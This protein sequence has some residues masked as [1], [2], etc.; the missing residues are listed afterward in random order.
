MNAELETL[1]TNLAMALNDLDLDELP[2]LGVYRHNVSLNIA[3]VDQ[4]HQLFNLVDVEDLYVKDLLQCCCIEVVK[5][6]DSLIGLKLRSH[7]S[8]LDPIYWLRADD[9]LSGE[10]MSRVYDSLVEFIDSIPDER[11]EAQ[12]INLVKC[13][14]LIPWRSVLNHIVNRPGDVLLG[15]LNHPQ[16]FFTPSVG[17]YVKI[18][19]NHAQLDIEP[20]EGILTKEDYGDDSVWFTISEA[21]APNTTNVLTCKS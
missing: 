6:H 9:K 18:K 17:L 3:S 8:N 2:W 7:R 16:R 19:G 14:A 13:G 5:L 10:P 12:R 4:L 21:K 15:C 1:V 11:K 20:D